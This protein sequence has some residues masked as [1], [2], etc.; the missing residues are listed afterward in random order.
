MIAKMMM[1]EHLV[2]K[3][4]PSRSK[5]WKILIQNSWSSIVWSGSNIQYLI[6]EFALEVIYNKMVKKCSGDIYQ[7]SGVK[8]TEMTS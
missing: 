2:E 8:S 3:L 5:G 1:D 4:D 6:S 7:I